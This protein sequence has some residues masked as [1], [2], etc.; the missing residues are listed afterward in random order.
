MKT[1]SGKRMGKILQAKGFS[2]VRT[3]GSHC[4][5]RGGNPPRT[6]PVPVHGNR[7]LKPGTQRRIMSQAGLVHADL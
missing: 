4:I 2:L 7:D 5:Y 1:V 3:T 6:V